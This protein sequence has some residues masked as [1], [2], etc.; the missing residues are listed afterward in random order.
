MALVQQQQ[1]LLRQRRRVDALQAR[2]GVARR[3]GEQEWIFKQFHRRQR[4][5]VHRQGQ[6]GRVAI[7][8]PQLPGQN[9]GLFFDQQQLQLRQRRADAPHR[10]RKHIA[11]QGR[12]RAQP[13][14]AGEGIVAA[15]RN[16]PDQIDFRQDAAGGGDDALPRLGRHHR[17]VVAL[18]QRGAEFVLQ[19]LDL[20]AEGRLADETALRRLAEAVQVGDGH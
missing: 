5:V 13:E 17:A 3:D 18:K 9:V 16:L 12:H 10:R 14:R 6:Q 4:R 15:G 11:C 1:L 19:L 20:G 8:R 2:Q 7:P